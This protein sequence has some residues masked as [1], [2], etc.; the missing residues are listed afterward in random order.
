MLR[1]EKS[2]LLLVACHFKFV[3]LSP[4][5]IILLQFQANMILGSRKHDNNGFYDDIL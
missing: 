2:Y 3:I 4:N 1:Q 5:T